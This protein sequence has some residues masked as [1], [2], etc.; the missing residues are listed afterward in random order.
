M[1]P[2]Q[3][4]SYKSALYSNWVPITNT[5]T[6]DPAKLCYVQDWE[7]SL[8]LPVENKTAGP[9]GCLSIRYGWEKQKGVAGMHR[10]YVHEWPASLDKN[11]PTI[12]KLRQ[13]SFNTESLGED[14]LACLEDNLRNVSTYSQ[15]SPVHVK[16]AWVGDSV[17]NHLK[18]AL[19]RAFRDIRHTPVMVGPMSNEIGNWLDEGLRLQQFGI[20][21]NGV[22]LTTNTDQLIYDIRAK[23]AVLREADVVFVKFVMDQVM[24]GMTTGQNRL[25][26]QDEYHHGLLRVTACLRNICPFAKIVII[27]P[28]PIWTRSPYYRVEDEWGMLPT[29]AVITKLEAVLERL[30]QEF[31]INDHA[32]TLHFERALGEM[33]GPWVEKTWG[34]HLHPVLASFFMRDLIWIIAEIAGKKL[35]QRSGN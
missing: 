18:E 6:R 9:S 11:K 12:N 13:A 27:G 2:E 4:A 19:E 35:R 33:K 10:G 22:P 32:C 15:L 1:T 8:T 20:H 26:L 7:K 28:H 25:L 29:V 23:E 31:M 17:S 3:K 24:I 14:F 16:V 21:R 5:N 30:H 34:I